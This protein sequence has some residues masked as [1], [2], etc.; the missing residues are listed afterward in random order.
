MT[1]TAKR[2]SQVRVK[3]DGEE[4]TIYFDPRSMWLKS[5]L[6]WTMVT[7]T[8][9]VSVGGCVLYFSFLEIGKDMVQ[10][11]VDTNRRLDEFNGHLREVRDELRMIATE[12]VRTRQG[13]TW[14]EMARTAN[15]AKYPDIVWPD[16]PK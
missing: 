3:R 16:L 10:L 8:A 11:G 2:R 15:H 6:V 12:F 9:S 5:T 1:G 13:Q 7:L 14:I 4:S